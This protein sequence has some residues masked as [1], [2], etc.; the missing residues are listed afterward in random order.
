MIVQVMDGRGQAAN[1][2]VQILILREA[3]DIPPRF[4]DST[5]N[6]EIRFDQPI[7]VNFYRV[8]ATDPDLKVIDKF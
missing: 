6:T 8:N 3:A 1:A 4:T 5:F 7:N 2:T